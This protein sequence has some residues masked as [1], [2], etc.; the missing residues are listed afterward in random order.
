M[1]ED[2]KALL[3]MR[4]A[5]QLMLIADPAYDWKARVSALIEIVDS[6]LAAAPVAEDPVFYPIHWPTMPPS[7]GQSP[8][9]FEDGYAEGWAKCLEGCMAAVEQA[10]PTPQAASAPSPSIHPSD[11]LWSRNGH[12]VCPSRVAASAPVGG[13]ADPMD[14]PLPCDVTV[15]HGT[16]RKGVPL[17]SLVRRMEVLYRMVQDQHVATRDSSSVD[18]MKIINDMAQSG[19]PQC[20]AC[21]GA[22]STAAPLGVTQFRYHCNVCGGTGLAQADP[23]GRAA[24]AATRPSEAAQPTV[25]AGA[26]DFE[27]CLCGSGYGPDACPSAPHATLPAPQAAQPTEQAAPVVN[28]QLTTQPSAQ[29]GQD[30]TGEVPEHLVLAVDRWFAENTGLGGCSD[31]DVADLAALFWGVKFEGG[32]ESLEDALAVVE[33]FGP[34]VQ[35]LNDTFARQIILAAEVRRLQGTYKSAVKSRSEMR[36]GLIATRQLLAE[37]KDRLDWLRENSCDLRCVDMPTGAGDADIHWSVIAHYESKPH[38]REVGRAYTDDP[39]AAIDAA[40]AAQAQEKG[41]HHAG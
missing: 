41:P 18:L 11:C 31:N 38:E 15:G 10:W 20:T 2:R 16:H 19:R 33:S 40:R 34:G 39:R 21:Q 23:W 26:G 14:T 35:G 22:G 29:P 17:R 5:M 3:E 6:A 36:Q 24:D 27:L 13:A 28:Q 32:R 25:Q 1:T 4:T 37:E 8:V 9:L 12:A 7:R 30:A